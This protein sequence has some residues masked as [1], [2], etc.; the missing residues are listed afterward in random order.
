MAQMETFIVPK[1]RQDKINPGEC[2]DHTQPT[3]LL[4]REFKKHIRTSDSFQTF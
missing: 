4:T 2:F 3:G 1:L